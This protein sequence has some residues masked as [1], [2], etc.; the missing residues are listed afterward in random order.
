MSE[1]AVGGGVAELVGVEAFDAGALGATTQRATEAVVSEAGTALPQPEMGG[2]GVAV[3]SAQ[4]EVPL[5]RTGDGGADRNDS[6]ST[7]FAAA[8]GDQTR[9]RGRRRRSGA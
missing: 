3:V 1:P 2:A 5:D 8:D 7:A 4:V 6:P 9:Q